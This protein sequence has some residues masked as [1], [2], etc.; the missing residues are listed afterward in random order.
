VAKSAFLSPGEETS[1]GGVRVYGFIRTDAF[2]QGERDY[3][4]V[5]TVDALVTKANA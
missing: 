1:F 3:A 4:V 5:E 2:G